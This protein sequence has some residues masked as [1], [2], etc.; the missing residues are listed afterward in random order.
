MRIESSSAR[1]TARAPDAPPAPGVHIAGSR[2]TEPNLPPVDLS[3]PS[4]VHVP[5]EPGLLALR[6]RSEPSGEGAFD[7]AWWPRSRNIHAE[8]PRL[9]GVLSPYLGPVDRIGLDADAWDGLGEPLYVEGR[10][11]QIDW[12]PVG[13][14]TVLVGRGVLGNYA[15]LAIPPEADVDEAYAA[16]TMATRISSRDAGQQILV[17]SA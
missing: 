10:R 13:E 11:I 5:V 6:L 7:G 15:L 12:F 3:A 1:A 17:A 9:I 4:A 14:D 16:M 8:L 2:D